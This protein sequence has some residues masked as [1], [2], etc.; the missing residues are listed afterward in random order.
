MEEFSLKKSKKDK[1]KDKKRELNRPPADE[2]P[3][4]AI[5][6]T[7]SIEAAA[8]KPE[9]LGDGSEA[10]RVSLDKPAVGESGEASE[11]V[12]AFSLKISKKDK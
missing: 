11:A 1:K 2:Q 7:P 5:V 4:A 9:I 6:P 3:S 12:Q 8:Q 10:R